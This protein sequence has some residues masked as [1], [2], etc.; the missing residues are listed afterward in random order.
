MEQIA[1][2]PPATHRQKIKETIHGH[3][4]SDPYRW[5]EDKTDESVI[6]WTR[7]QHESSLAWLVE[8]CP[9]IEGIKEDF[10]AYIDRDI[11]SSILLVGERQFYYFKKKGEQQYQLFTKLNGESVLLFDPKK[12]DPSG[13]ASI[14][15]TVYVKDGSKVAIGVQFKGDEINTYYIIDTTTGEEVAPKIEGLRYFSWTK[16]E[17]HAYIHVGTKEML[18]KQI[19]IKTYLHK[20]GSSRSEDVFLLSA[21]DSKLIVDIRDTQYSDLTFISEGDFYATHY[22]KVRKA[23][24]INNETTEIYNSQKYRVAP[25]AVGNQLY[26][27]TNHEA[28]NFKLMTAH[29]T[30]PKFEDWTVLYDEKDTVLESYIVTN[31][32]L[33]IQDKK[34]V[35]SRLLVHDLA[36][37]FIK[38]LKLPEIANVSYVKYHRESDSLYIG[39]SSFNSP[40]RLY[41]LAAKTLDNWQLFYQGKTPFNM[42]DIVSKVVFYPS[43]DGTKIPMFISHHKDVKLDGNNPS[44]LYGYG[45][46]NVGISPFYLA[47]H[48][49]FFK[50]GGIVAEA[51]I[52]GGNE[53]GENWHLD[54]MMHKKQNTFDDF[55][56]ATKYLVQEKYT[57]HQRIVIKGGSNG[58]LLIGA[59]LTQAPEICK[60]AICKVPLLD[61]LRFHK[62]LI[63]RYWI[64]EYGDPEKQEDFEYILNYSPYHNIKHGVNLPPTLV[65][66]GE[67]DTRVDPLHAKKFVARLQNNSSQ[68]NP[69]LLYMDYDSGHGS[70]KSMAAQIKSHCDEETFMMRSLGME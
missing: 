2:N 60:A 19:P 4:V 11:E 51:G 63:A 32:H 21:N 54:G 30:K 26:F 31:Y 47:R 49:T 52:R 50:K 61:M 14:S 12:L 46:F 66:A 67:N 70:G 65:V 41:Q 53:Y 9:P 62:F 39:L 35:L 24:N 45:G 44:L 68:T 37:N 55:I 48:Y 5:L 36:G 29:K 1:F 69:V 18:A 40:F 64:P 38:E 8:N 13:K 42:D 27:L 58:G 25:H 16:D 20:I 6:E 28:P 15:G 57:N 56:Y 59:V 33:I 23:G 34:D 10:T 3:E 17:E 7:K 43:K 22:L